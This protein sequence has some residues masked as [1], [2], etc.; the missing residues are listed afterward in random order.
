MASYESRRFKDTIPSGRGKTGKKSGG[1]RKKKD[2]AIAPDV[3]E[4]T[5]CRVC[6]SDSDHAKLLICDKCEAHYHTYCLAVPLM[7]V[8]RGD[9]FCGESLPSIVIS[10]RLS[11]SHSGEKSVLHLDSFS[12]TR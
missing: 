3:N 9:W 12:L 8:P 10:L 4:H 2:V 11:G 6:H 1:R 7:S 5:P